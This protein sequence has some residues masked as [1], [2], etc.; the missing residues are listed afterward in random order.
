MSQK[1]EELD[2]LCCNCNSFFPAEAGWTEEGICLSDS[3]FEPYLDELLENMNYGCC[4]ELIEKLKFDGNCE[5]CEHFDPVEIM[6]TDLDFE[7]G[8]Q[9]LAES[10]ELNV[11]SFQ[12]LLLRR[13]L[14]KMADPNYPL[15]SYIKLLT[16]KSKKEVEAGVNTLYYIMIQGNERAFTALWE[17]YNN[18]A[19]AE[20]LRDVHWKIY[21]LEKLQHGKNKKALFDCLVH[22]LYKTSSNNTTKGLIIKIFQIM[23]TLPVDLM[24]D[25]LLKMLKDKRFSYK[26][27]DKM[28]ELLGLKQKNHFFDM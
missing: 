5:V 15:E 8:V 12:Q 10:N 23:Y 6:S 13:E 17:Y 26:L 18:L 14:N 3:A 21:L 1:A 20:D 27:K 28:K 25:Q 2:R 16:S 24:K 4:K 22:E 11:E 19:P 9:E 7:E